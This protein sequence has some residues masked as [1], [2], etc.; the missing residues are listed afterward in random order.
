MADD[1]RPVAYLDKNLER[2]PYTDESDADG[3]LH[4]MVREFSSAL[5]DYRRIPFLMNV[6]LKATKK[7]FKDRATVSLFVN[8]LFTLAPDYEVNGVVKRRSGTPYFGM[9]LMLNL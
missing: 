7:L 9:E 5:L 1:S 3:I 2:H 6:N 8:R 4:Q